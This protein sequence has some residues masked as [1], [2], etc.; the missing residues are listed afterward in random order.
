M[1]DRTYILDRDYEADAYK[2]NY[3][4][5][6]STPD[7]LLTQYEETRN[8]IIRFIED[9]ANRLDDRHRNALKGLLIADQALGE[10]F[11]S[12]VNANAGIHQNVGRLNWELYRLQTNVIQMK[13]NDLFR[14][15]AV[16][17]PQPEPTEE[18]DALRRL[19]T[20]LLRKIRT[21]NELLEEGGQPV[22]P[23]R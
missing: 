17:G 1:A 21:M 16:D 19:V 14:P 8:A 23:V 4:G 10:T 22:P 13:I 11:E 2:P 18:L 7:E 5:R 20:A 9:D 3:T 15:E 6:Y 12:L